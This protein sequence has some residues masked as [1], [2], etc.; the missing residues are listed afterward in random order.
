VTAKQTRSGWM[1]Y[2]AAGQTVFL[3]DIYFLYSEVTTMTENVSTPAQRVGDTTKYKSTYTYYKVT[4]TGQVVDDS[5]VVSS[6]PT[7]AASQ[8][9]QG[10]S[11]NVL[12]Y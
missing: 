12:V 5:M 8:Q 10:L 1:W 4:K 3:G 6:Y 11:Q 2:N 9:L 7:P